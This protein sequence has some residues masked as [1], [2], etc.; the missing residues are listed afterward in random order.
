MIREMHNIGLGGH[1]GFEKTKEMVEEKYNWL[2][3]GT[4]VESGSNNVAHAN[5]LKGKVRL[6]DSMHLFQ[7]HSLCGNTSMWILF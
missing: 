1:F 7:C 5:M 6:L 4:D 3:L 2:G